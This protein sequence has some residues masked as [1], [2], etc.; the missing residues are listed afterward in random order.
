MICGI[1]VDLNPI[2]AGEALV[3]EEARHTSA[4]DRIEGR[5]MR[6]A[7]KL[8]GTSQRAHDPY[9]AQSWG[10]RENA[11]ALD[12]TN[13][14]IAA[15]YVFRDGSQRFGGYRREEANERQRYEFEEYL[16]SLHGLMNALGT[17]IWPT[18]HLLYAVWHQRSSDPR[19]RDTAIAAESDRTDNVLVPPGPIRLR[20]P[21]LH[22]T[23]IRHV[24]NP[25]AF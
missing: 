24:S 4:Y 19:E 16:D 1:Y 15:K 14:Y 13:P 11:Y 12:P 3:P 8:A 23:N 9:T 18:Y 22:L 10:Y 2:R 17:E 7:A 5:K 25:P 20:R 21:N 6:L